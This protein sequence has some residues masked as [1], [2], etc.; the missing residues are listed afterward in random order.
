MEKVSIDKVFDILKQNELYH[1]VSV[2]KHNNFTYEKKP[3]T[4]SNAQSTVDIFQIKCSPQVNADKAKNA[5]ETFKKFFNQVEFSQELHKGEKMPEYKGFKKVFSDEDADLIHKQGEV[6]L[7]DV[8][9][10]WCGPCQKPMKHNQ[11][12]LEKNEETWKGK[13]RIVAVSVDDDK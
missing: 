2:T 5:K 13:A 3:S 6:L 11:E 4:K 1:H 12:M 8:W 7:V 10:T 9:A